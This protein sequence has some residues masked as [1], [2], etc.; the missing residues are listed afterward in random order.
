MTN[1]HIL[2]QDDLEPTKTERQ[3]IIDDLE[4][5]NAEW[6]ARGLLER[7]VPQYAELAFRRH[8]SQAYQV[9]LAPY[10]EAALDQ[11]RAQKEATLSPEDY[12]TTTMAAQ[13]RLHAAT[14]IKAPERRLTPEILDLIGH[15]PVMTAGENRT[16]GIDGDDTQ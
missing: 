5:K 11:V 6:V 15:Q 7:D 13:E 2:C 1:K 3:A 4:A 8:R 10:F 9:L 14:G 16:A 12:R